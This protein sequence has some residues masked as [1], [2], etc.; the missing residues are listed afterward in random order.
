LALTA[1][2]TVLRLAPP[3]VIS[4]AEIETVVEAIGSVLRQKEIGD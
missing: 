3:L 4:R 1:G 2:S